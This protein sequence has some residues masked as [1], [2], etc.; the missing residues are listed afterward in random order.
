MGSSPSAA[1]ERWRRAARTSGPRC[2]LEGSS[3]SDGV[4]CEWVLIP[5]LFGAHVAEISLQCPWPLAGSEMLSCA[6]SHWLWCT[7]RLIQRAQPCV[8]CRWRLA[9][10]AVPILKAWGLHFQGIAIATI[11]TGP[12][13]TYSCAQECKRAYQRGKRCVTCHA[14]RYSPCSPIWS[15]V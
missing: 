6:W 2:V 13:P 15:C 1:S 4:H 9:R 3:E 11:C 12:G 5:A 8:M 10:G 7:A 14:G